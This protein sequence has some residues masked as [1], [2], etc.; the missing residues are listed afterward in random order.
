MWAPWTLLSM[1]QSHIFCLLCIIHM[2]Y[3]HALLLSITLIR[4]STKHYKVLLYHVADT[5]TAI[6]GVATSDVQLICL[7]SFAV[8]ISRPSC[9]KPQRAI[10]IQLG[11]NQLRLMFSL[12]MASSLIRNHSYVAIHLS[13]SCIWKSTSTPFT[14]AIF[15]R[16]NDSKSTVKTK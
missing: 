7:S 10:S 16:K 8:K 12:L 2:L 15:L 4:R 11:F 13:T 9:L 5:E 14:T 1:C 3:S 6:L